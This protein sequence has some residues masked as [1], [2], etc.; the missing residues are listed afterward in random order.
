MSDEQI[1]ISKPVKIVSDA[2]ERVAYDLMMTIHVS[3]KDTVIEKEA[4]KTREYWLKL[5]AQ[6]YNAASGH[7]LKSI[8]KDD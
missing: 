2:K 5:Y 1:S 6:C 7:S 3:C 8:L 4:Q